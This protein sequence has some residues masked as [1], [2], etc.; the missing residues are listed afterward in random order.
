MGEG[1]D[2][3]GRAA[4]GRDQG[5]PVAALRARREYER[6]RG[7]GL[8]TGHSGARRLPSVA[9]RGD[10]ESG[11]SRKGSESRVAEEAVVPTDLRAESG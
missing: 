2:L 5:G 3:C 4:A 7:P 8:V 1:H 11:S 6:E 9:D 10:T